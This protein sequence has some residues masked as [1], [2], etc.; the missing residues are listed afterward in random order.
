[1][2]SGPLRVE[3]EVKFENRNGSAEAQARLSRI[4]EQLLARKAADFDAT[5]VAV[6]DAAFQVGGRDQP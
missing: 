2:V 6:R 5:G 3:V 4:A 1:M